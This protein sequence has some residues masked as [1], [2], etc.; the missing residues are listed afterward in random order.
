MVQQGPVAAVF[1]IGL[2]VATGPEHIEQRGQIKLWMR[3]VMSSSR[4]GWVSGPEPGGRLEL[5]ARA[6]ME[7]FLRVL[8]QGGL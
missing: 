7:L 5:R 2:G 3:W 6:L 1:D 4:D 8:A